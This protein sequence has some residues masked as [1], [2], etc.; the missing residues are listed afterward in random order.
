MKL[1]EIRKE[2]LNE[3]APKNPLGLFRN[4]FKAAGVNFAEVESALLLALKQLDPKIASLTK[5]TPEQIEKAFKTTTFKKYSQT[6][7]RNYIANNDKVIEG[8]LK[9][10]Q[11][12]TT[13]GSKMAR[14]EIANT[15]GV[16]KSIADD[17]FV[18]KKPKK[19]TPT[20]QT[21]KPQSTTSTPNVVSNLT[22][23]QLWNKLVTDFESYNVPIKLTKEQQMHFIQQLK[24]E[25]NRL[26][27]EIEP[28]LYKTYNEIY[29]RYQKLT[30]EKR[31]LA[32][33]ES[34]RIIKEKGIGLKGFNKYAFN[35][36]EY[37]LKSIQ[38]SKESGW[39]SLKINVGLTIAGIAFEATS[40]KIKTNEWDVENVFGFSLKQNALFKSLVALVSVFTMGVPSYILAISNVLISA[41]NSIG[42]L[43]GPDVSVKKSNSTSKTIFGD[44][45]PSEEELNNFDNN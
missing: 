13:Q 24:P 44:D 10:H 26:Y 8:I 23:E 38:Q 9:K 15:L 41:I 21:P 6:I 19:V 35:I 7:A 32:L 37:I 36:K 22:D 45:P 2:I 39:K 16:N 18:I 5:A 11:I 28:T 27:K 31:Q 17:I 12:N 14:L 3:A 20:I 29:D 1:V 33:K 40:N 25:I 30:P 42:A 4:I 43:T 34:Q